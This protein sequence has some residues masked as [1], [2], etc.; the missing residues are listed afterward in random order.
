[1]S[2]IDYDHKDIKAFEEMEKEFKK[3]VQ[4]VHF[5]IN[6]AD[7]TEIWYYVYDDVKMLTDQYLEEFAEEERLKNEM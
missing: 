1:M 4:R 6:K 7:D 2:Y 3:Y 5:L